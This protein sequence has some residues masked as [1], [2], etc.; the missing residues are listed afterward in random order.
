MKKYLSYESLNFILTSILFSY[1]IIIN[2][3][4]TLFIL[5]NESNITIIIINKF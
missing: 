3:I 5:K 2:F 1:I 4:F